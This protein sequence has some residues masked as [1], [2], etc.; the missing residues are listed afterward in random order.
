MPHYQAKRIA[1]F[2]NF[3]DGDACSVSDQVDCKWFATHRSLSDTSLR[4]SCE[5]KRDSGVFDA[6]VSSLAIFTQQ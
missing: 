1:R 2:F 5:I 6:S 3:F 4:F